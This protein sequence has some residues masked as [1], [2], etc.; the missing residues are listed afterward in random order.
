MNL[1]EDPDFFNDVLRPP[2]AAASVSERTYDLLKIIF[3][4]EVRDF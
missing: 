1:A 4:I 3:N 2:L